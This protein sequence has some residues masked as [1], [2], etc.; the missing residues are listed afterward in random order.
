MNHTEN[1]HASGRSDGEKVEMGG[2]FLSGCMP[3]QRKYVQPLI[4]MA[5]AAAVW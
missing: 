2:E 5:A 3:L 1:A 4:A